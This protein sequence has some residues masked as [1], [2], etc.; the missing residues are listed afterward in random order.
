M[1]MKVTMARSATALRALIEN[2]A[3]TTGC[4]FAPIQ[5]DISD[6]N[7]SYT[8]L[9]CSNVHDAMKIIGAVADQGDGSLIQAV[10]VK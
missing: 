4:E 8:V 2:Y 10:L 5:V 9:L 7:P 1:R 3:E 6:L